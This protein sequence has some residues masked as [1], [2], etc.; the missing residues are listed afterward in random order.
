MR[1]IRVAMVEDDPLFREPL[2]A[3]VERERDMELVGWAADGVEGIRLVR[4]VRFDVL[5]LDLSLPRLDGLELL[6]Q[7]R[8]SG[9]RGAVLVLTG[10]NSPRAASAALALGADYVLS[11][12]STWRLVAGRIRLLEGGLARQCEGLL[13]KLGAK[14]KWL[15]T[16][17][18]A[19]CAGWLGEHRGALLKEAYID[20]AARHHCTPEAVEKNVR[21][22]VTRLSQ[23]S[24]GY[25][26]LFG[27]VRASNGDFLHRLVWEAIKE[28]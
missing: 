21:M 15:G 7:Y 27:S 19:Q 13:L 5:L 2:M 4:E 17:Q 1:P 12:P 16:A 14:E 9:G 20:V 28:L 24:E 6:R 23:R 11:K 22:V 25:Q 18:A 26:A 8:L 3:R 10:A